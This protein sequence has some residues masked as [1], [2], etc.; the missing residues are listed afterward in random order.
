ME[1]L[2]GPVDGICDYSVGGV[3]GRI[4]SCRHGVFGL[5][6]HFNALVPSDYEG[7][8]EYLAY[9]HLPVFCPVILELVAVHAL[10]CLGGVMHPVVVNLPVFSGGKVSLADGE[11]GVELV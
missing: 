4:H 3:P 11:G 10:L 2:A 7:A 1:E 8:A 9:V 6:V 5:Q